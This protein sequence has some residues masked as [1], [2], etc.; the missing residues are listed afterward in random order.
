[1]VS[2][3]KS[4][5][6]LTYGSLS[7]LCLSLAIAA[8]SPQT[9]PSP[10]PQASS[11][12]PHASPAAQPSTPPTTTAAI[13]GVQPW[14][15]LLPGETAHG[16]TFN[17]DGTLSYQNKTLL[18]KIPVSYSSDGS[19][20]T[21]TYAKR[22]LISA[23]SPSGAFNFVRACESPTNETGLCWSFFLVNRQQETAQKVAVGKYGGLE[24]VQWSPDEHYAVFME[25]LEGS[26]WF[27]V[28]DLQTGDS[29]SFEELRDRPDLTRFTWTND[30]TFQ[31]NVSTC[32]GSTCTSP[33]S[34]TGDINKLFL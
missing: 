9:T 3:T 22:L 16:F 30:H 11:P 6:G 4:W 7:C 20:G 17:P 13:P 27:H 1:M 32:N 21:V 33:S 31:V 19:N 10:S 34:F 24:W 28:V 14:T 23:P 18:S 5:T 25:P 15:T 8:C 12:T 2:N 26:F 29:K